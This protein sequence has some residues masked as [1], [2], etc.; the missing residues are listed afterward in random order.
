[1]CFLPRTRPVRRIPN[2][3]IKQKPNRFTGH[4]ISTQTTEKNGSPVYTHKIVE[5]LYTK[6]SNFDKKSKNSKKKSKNSKKRRKS[7]KKIK[8]Q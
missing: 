7:I 2:A 4:K 5:I 8:N 6:K 3:L 1:M